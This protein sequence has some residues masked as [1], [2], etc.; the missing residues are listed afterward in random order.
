MFKPI[1]WHTF[2]R[3]FII[4]QIGFALFALAIA[5]LI[6]ANLGTSPWVMLTVALADITGLTTGTMTVIVGFVVLI[7]SLYLK[8][9]IGWGTVGNILSIGPWLDLWLMVV[10]SVMGNWPFQLLML[11][12]SALLMGIASAVYIGVNAG[13]GPRDTLMLAVERNTRLS[14]RQ[15]RGGIELIVLIVGFALGGPLGIGTVLFALLIGPSV[16]WAFRLFKVQREETPPS[17]P[18]ATD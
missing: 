10:P 16:Q 9:Q 13:A 3:D 14:L 1:R 17:S 5:L 11:G 4:I 8:E 2:I 7:F 6:Q 15:A 18:A 12:A